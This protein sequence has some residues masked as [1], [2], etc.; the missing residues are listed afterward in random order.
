MHLHTFI[1]PK[2]IANAR[3]AIA[4]GAESAG[5]KPDEIKTCS[6]MATLLNPSREDYLRKVVAR[7][8]TYMQAPGYAEMLAQLNEWDAEVITEFRA[9]AMVASMLGSIDSVASLEQL[10]AIEK[11]IPAE[12]LSAVATGTPEQCAERL[13]QEMQLGVDEICL[14]AST[15]DEFAPM[16]AAYAELKDG[17]SGN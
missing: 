5:R 13:Y 4:E 1:T 11:L 2:G 9:D 16:L 15:P 14:H 6:V 7:M 3:G 17:D 10:E 8:A 12:W